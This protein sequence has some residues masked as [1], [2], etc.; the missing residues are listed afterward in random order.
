MKKDRGTTVALVKKIL[1]ERY[2]LRHETEPRMLWAAKLQD[3]TLEEL[4]IRRGIASVIEVKVGPR[5]ALR[6][7][8][9]A[10][11]RHVPH[12]RKEHEL[13]AASGTWRDR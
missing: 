12:H 9:D 10:G 1:S 6:I 4:V 3:L 13:R 8:T 7:A 11:F 2:E 5:G